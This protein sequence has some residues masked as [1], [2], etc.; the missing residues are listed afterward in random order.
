MPEPKMG[1]RMGSWESEVGNGQWM[2]THLDFN[3]TRLWMT[4]TLLLIK[5]SDIW[6]PTCPREQAGPLKA[7]ST[8]QVEQ[9]KGADAKM[10]GMT[11]EQDAAEHDSREAWPVS[12]APGTP[13]VGIKFNDVEIS[14]SITMTPESC[15]AGID[16]FT[17]MV[18]AK[19]MRAG[20]IAGSDRITMRWND[21][22][23]GGPPAGYFIPKERAERRFWWDGDGRPF[24]AA[25]I[26]TRRKDMS[27]SLRDVLCE[28]G[29]QGGQET[30]R[31]RC[32]TFSKY[33]MGICSGE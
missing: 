5:T 17:G 1:R 9:H 18:I 13:Q 21:P 4:P 14:M 10:H 32:G 8:E 3:V 24:R 11:Q 27:E 7:E 2:S 20:G 26:P 6:V 16:F 30:L 29:L 28:L 25:E 12:T 23:E 33:S 31:P 19:Q 15:E 22:S